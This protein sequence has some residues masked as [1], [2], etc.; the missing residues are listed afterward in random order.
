ML[1]MTTTLPSS[2]AEAGYALIPAVQ[3][4]AEVAAWLDRLP[5]VPAGTRGGRRG[6]LAIPEVGAF[7]RAGAFGALARDLLGPGAF[8]VRAICFDKTP[9]AN[10]SVPWHQD[11]TICVEE[12]HE[13]PGYGP[14]SVKR[15][16]EWQAPHVRPPVC[17]LENMLTLRLHLDHTPA[18]HGALMVRPGSHRRGIC[19]Q[20]EIADL[21]PAVTLACGAGAVVVMR[22]LLWHASQPAA[23]PGH[24]RV[25][26]VEYAAADLPAPLCWRLDG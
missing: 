4:P 24:R 12:R 3:T 20:A 18:D 10:W 23:R 16:G 25:L 8:P 26:H 21:P 14:W 7:A 1:A 17:I 22:P 2:L 9:E 6:M 11:T 15:E 5:P 19:T 13:V